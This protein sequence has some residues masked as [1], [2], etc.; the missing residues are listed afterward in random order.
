MEKIETLEQ[1][2][3]RFII[4][5]ENSFTGIPDFDFD[6]IESECKDGESFEDASDRLLAEFYSII[7]SKL[8]KEFPK[9]PSH[10]RHNDYPTKK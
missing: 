4:L 8:G 3:Q 2:F 1:R 7:N 5:F 6:F 10:P 9:A